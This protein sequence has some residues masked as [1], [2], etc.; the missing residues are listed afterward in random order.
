MILFRLKKQYFNTRGAAKEKYYI[1][2]R[3]NV[4]ITTKDNGAGVENIFYQI[5]K[6]ETKKES[7]D[8]IQIELP[9]EFKGEITAWVEDK[10][11]NRGDTAVSKYIVCDAKL[12]QI[13]IHTDLEEGKWY[14]QN[15]NAEIIVEE[16]GVS[17][18]VASIRCYFNPGNR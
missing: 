8:E 17:S 18:G 2:K 16:N 11:G 10:A 15:V 1:F 9:K 13:E 4:K 6:G 3:N 5:G 7:A 12:P 14:S